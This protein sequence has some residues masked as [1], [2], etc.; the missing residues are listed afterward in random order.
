MTELEATKKAIIK[1][2]QSIT[3]SEEKLEKQRD[4]LFQLQVHET[5][6]DLG[7]KPVYQ[8]SSKR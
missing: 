4:I 1:I 3:Q 5:I 6:L 2:E 8:E 7:L